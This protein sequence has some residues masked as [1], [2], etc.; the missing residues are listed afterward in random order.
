MSS[1]SADQP[2][3]FGVFVP[4]GWRMD[5]G[6]IHD[7]VEQYAA[8][9]R[10]ARTAEASGLDSIWLYDHLQTMPEPTLEPT[11]ECWTT[12]AA[13]ARDTQRV[14]IG[15]M[16]TCNAFRHPALL[17]KMASTVDALSAGRLIVGLGA[18]W[19]AR[20]AQA[21]GLPFPETPVRMRMFAEAC[22]VLVRMWTEDQ[23]QFAGRWYSLSGPINQPRGVQRPHVPLWIA[24]GGE[25]VTLR[26]AARWGDAC[27]VGGPPEQIRHKLGVLR[28]HC[29][30]IGR[31]Y[32][33]IT[34]STSVEELYLVNHE[35]EV[36]A[37]RERI[38][39]SVPPALAATV[40]VETPQRI[41]EHLT[42]R[43]RAGANYFIVYLRHAAYEVEQIELFAREVAPGVQAA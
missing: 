19:D 41:A 7:P 27:N 14:K 12:T 26:L 40:L 8:M 43:A 1:T 30:D 3:R 39:R 37:A 16:A 6:Q 25:S 10:V 2:I 29:D 17:A 11:F 32:D 42:Q 31:D 34:R 38:E 36:P 13:L 4:Q 35:R 20:E 23:P 9:V 15:Q 21:Y 22:E 33:A 24:G 5:L 28:R 18:C